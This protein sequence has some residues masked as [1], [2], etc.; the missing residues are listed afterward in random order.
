M[1]QNILSGVLTLSLI[2]LNPASATSTPITS[3]VLIKE[4]VRDYHVKEGDTLSKIAEKEYGSGNFWT[5]VWNENPWIENPNL[6]EKDWV[7]KLSQEKPTTVATL[8]ANL[9]ILPALPI[10]AQ[11]QTQNQTGNRTTIVSGP[12]NDVQI[13]YLGNCESGMTATR[14]SGN[15]YYGAFQFSIGTWNSMQTGY[16]RADLAPLEVQISAVQRLVARS[17]IFTQFPACARKMRSIGLI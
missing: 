7:L 10:Q 14:N 5:N 17:S 15:G 2:L 3:Q 9:K 8:S 11:S 12:L 1:E 13:T 4:E 6:I 16:E